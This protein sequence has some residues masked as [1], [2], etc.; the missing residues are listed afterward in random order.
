MEV[1]TVLTFFFRLRALKITSL[2][3]STSL[4]VLIVLE[5]VEATFSDTETFCDAT[6]D[7]VATTGDLLSSKFGRFLI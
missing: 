1:A 4:L 7:R 2:H 5:I 3:F 6:G